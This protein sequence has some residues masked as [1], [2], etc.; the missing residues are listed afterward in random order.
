MT[1]APK[2]IPLATYPSSI[3][4]SFVKVILCTVTTMIVNLIKIQ[5]SLERAF[6]CIEYTNIIVM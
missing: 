3:P 1:T 4:C 5:S 6:Q 2:H